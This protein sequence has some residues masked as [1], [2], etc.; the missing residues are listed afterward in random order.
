MSNP[1][2]NRRFELSKKQSVVQVP[3]LAVH[4]P[5]CLLGD[6]GYPQAGQGY[7]GLTSSVQVVSLRKVDATQI[8]CFTTVHPLK[9][10]RLPNSEEVQSDA[11]YQLALKLMPSVYNHLK[12]EQELDQLN[13]QYQQLQENADFNEAADFDLVERGQIESQI[14]RLKEAKERTNQQILKGYV[15]YR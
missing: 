11:D 13:R 9:K 7:F 3:E 6:Y 15:S 14:E 4:Y 1:W 8:E 2:W 5:D 10:I 12:V